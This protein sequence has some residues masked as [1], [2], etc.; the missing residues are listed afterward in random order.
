MSYLCLPLQS[1]GW[2]VGT[3]C[4]YRH[5]AVFPP[6]LV[7]PPGQLSVR[8]VPCSTG[9]AGTVTTLLHV[10]SLVVQLVSVKIVINYQRQQLIC[11]K[12]NHNALSASQKLITY[13]HIILSD[14]I[15]VCAKFYCMVKFP[16]AQLNLPLQIIAIS[17]T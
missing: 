5:V 1:G 14:G 12:H 4:P 8:V 9:S 11:K 6:R 2:L 7:Y 15:D 13:H 16:V 10:K 3:T 17:Q